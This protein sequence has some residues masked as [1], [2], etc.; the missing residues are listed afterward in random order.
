MAYVE[1][2]KIYNIIATMADGEKHRIETM[3]YGV[4]VSLETHI[5]YILVYIYI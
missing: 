4:I 2:H 5:Q 1:K 3:A